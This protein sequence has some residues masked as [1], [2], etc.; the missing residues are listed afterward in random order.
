MISINNLTIEYS[1]RFIF[2]DVS[3]NINK[4]EKVGLIGRNGSGKTT[5]LRLIY[6]SE[7]PHSGIITKPND[8]KIGYLP[9]EGITLSEKLLF[10]EVKSSL[11][12]ITRI[13]QQIKDITKHLEKRIDYDSE[14]FIKLTQKL[15]ETT[16]R[17]D[18]LGGYNLDG[19]IEKVL[20]GLGFERDEFWRRS[21]EFSGGWQ[22][23]IELAKILLQRPDCILLDEPTNHLDIDSIQWLENYLKNYE[24]SVVIVSHDKSFLDN[25]TQKT[26]EISMGK[27][28]IMNLKYSDFL[29]AREEQ[30]QQIYNQYKAQ[31]KEIEQTERFIDRFRYKATL[32]SRVQ[33]RIKQLEKKELIQIEEEDNSEIVVK[34][35]EV[36]RSGSMVVSVRNLTKQYGDKLVLNDINFELN[37]GDR[38]AF[39]GKNGEGKTTFTKIL[40]GLENFEGVIEFGM[41]VRI[42][43]YS[44][45]QA[46]LLDSEDTVFEV[47]DRVATGDMRT[48]IRSLL[49]AFLFS[50]DSIY[51][52]VKVL[53]GGEKSRLALARLLLEPINLLL[54]DEPTNHLDMVAKKV[55]KNALMD[56]GG[57]LVIV[58]HDRD[59]LTDVTTKTYLFKNKSIKEYLGDISYFLNN[60]NIEN[61]AELNKAEQFSKSQK[62]LERELPGKDKIK[63]EEQ[64]KIQR[65]I[66][67]AHKKIKRIEEEIS[68]IE[69]DIIKIE[70]EFANPEIMN[71]YELM[72]QKASIYNQLKKE[73]DE[74][75]QEW[76]D[77]HKHLER[78]EGT[79]GK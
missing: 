56:F 76:E 15:S 58:S 63:R 26:I 14:E 55:L 62:M 67:S 66:S 11:I 18:I 52:K 59:F 24:S 7:K 41:N 6:G 33:S 65:E 51:K 46:D 54:L 27:L 72:N 50:G 38:V 74:K 13:E 77:L 71:D 42:G 3:F 48:K 49:G 60:Y 29:K 16:H 35:P 40:A 73:I 45:N 12:E 69:G 30:K 68:S 36:P 8:L 4:N 53:S 79:F 21:N 31:Q 2:N 44:Q 9:Q 19:E 25:V 28:Y 37:R 75:Y 61:L 70:E 32:A 78:I 1:G 43:Y 34:F 57:T 64:K 39:V 5:L 47:I 22:M 10:E 20:K 23:R 17:F